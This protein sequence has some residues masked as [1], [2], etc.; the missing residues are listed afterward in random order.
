MSATQR[1]GR[2][3]FTVLLPD[4]R[5]EPVEIHDHLSSLRMALVEKDSVHLLDRN[6]DRPGVYLLLDGVAED[7]SFGVYVGKAPAGIRSRLLDHERKKTWARAL[8][9]QRD[10]QHGLNSAHIG[11]LEGDLYDLFD[12]AE[13]GRLHNGPRTGDETVPTY[14]LRILESFRDPIV[15]VLRLLGYDP[16]TVDDTAASAAT[17]KKP[18]TYY[19]IGLADLLAAGLINVGDKLVSANGSWPASA[20]ISVGGILYNGTEY[21]SP[22]TAAAAVKG[23]AAN[24]WDFWAVETPDGSK[25]LSAIRAHHQQSNGLSAQSP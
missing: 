16:A 24:G 23:G 7:S 25:R 20:E 19:G 18:A 10:T 4:T 17:L 9:I 1:D 21:A 2:L 12:A 15:R 3:P 8:L 5:L 6:W 13:R 22:S 14:D 11:W